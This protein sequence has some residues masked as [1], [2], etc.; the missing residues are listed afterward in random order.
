MHIHDTKGKNRWE[1]EEERRG[2]RTI[3]AAWNSRIVNS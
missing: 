3:S 2:T 1:K